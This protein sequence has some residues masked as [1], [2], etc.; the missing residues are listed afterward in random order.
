MSAVPT[1]LA[2]SGKQ[3]ALLSAHLFPGDGKEAVAILLC[4]R[5]RNNRRNSL[6]VRHVY[7]VPYDACRVRNA[8]RVSWRPNAVTEAFTLAMNEEL[9]IVKVHSHPGGYEAFSDTDDISDLELFPSIFGWLDTDEPQASVIML[10]GGRMFGRLIHTK[11]IG[12]ALSEIRVAGDDFLF[13][14]HSAPVREESIPSFARRIAQTFGNAT[15]AKLRSLRIGV[16]G[17]SG[18]GS[19]VV[20]L[21]ARNCVGELVLIDPEV[22]DEGNLNRI[23]NSTKTDVD[24]GMPKVMLLK[25]AVDA[26]GLGTVVHT[27]QDDIMKSEIIEMLASC[28]VI[29]GCMDSIDG[30]HILNKIAS[31]YLIP[32]I[33]LGVRIDADGRGGVDHVSGVVHTLQPGGSSLLSRGMYDMETLS[34]AMMHRR[35]PQT[36]AERL[37]QGY[38]RGAR[39]DQPAVISVN[40]ATAALAA[41]EFLAR[42]HPYRVDPNGAFAIRRIVLSDPSASSDEADG[43]PCAT[44]GKVIGLGDRTPLL[45]LQEL[46]KEAENN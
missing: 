21:L 26:M 41:N 36:Y 18:T 20:E 15:Y 29:F 33:D 45:G 19:I 34:S 30:R 1:T 3:H 7:P 42:L 2:L 27:F 31:Y 11:R 14:Q 25:R 35:D 24:L 22:V 37:K 13:W 12:E 10:P 32:Y 16:V 40:M 6:L 5:S 4:G 28:D 43:K 44:F 46:S 9:S 17:C 23:L 38:V 8:F 39:V